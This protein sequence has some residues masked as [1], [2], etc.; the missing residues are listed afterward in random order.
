VRQLALAMAMAATAATACG[1]RHGNST[2]VKIEGHTWKVEVAADPARRKKGMAGRSD[3]PPGT[4]MLFV[5][6]EPD[7]RSFWMEGCLVP[8]DIAFINEDMRVTAVYTMPVEPDHAGRKNYTSRSR[9]LYVL[10][11]RAGELVKAGVAAGSRVK[12]SGPIPEA[13]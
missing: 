3:V 1:C 9:V 6:P 5:F 12:I 11:T 10:E 13:E 2:R 8:L 4:G 7:Y